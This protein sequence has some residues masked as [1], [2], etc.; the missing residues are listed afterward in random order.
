MRWG[1]EGMHGSHLMPFMCVGVAYFVIAVIVPVVL[2]RTRGEQ[3]EWT[4]S[5]LI[6]STA[7]G[8]AGALGALGIILALNFGGSAIY[9]MPLVFGG[10]PVVNT[11]VSMYMSKTY[12]EAGPLFFAGLILV[13]TGAAAVLYFNP[14]AKA[15]KSIS[16]GDFVKVLCSIALTAVCWGG[17]GPV[18]HKGQMAMRG[19]RLRPF[20]CVGLAY[21]LVAVC[22]PSLLKLIGQDHGEFTLSGASW[23]LAGGTAGA[24]GALG[25]ILA[26]TFGGKPVMVMP[27]VFG[28]AP[29][30]NTLLSIAT[31]KDLGEP[32]VFFYAGLLIVVAGAAT[33]LIFAP[34][35]HP[36]KK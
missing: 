20:M 5:G 6:W 35:P 28:I 15:A 31:A 18:L 36:V 17:Y 24:C 32:Q 1:T 22:V 9:V 25:I 27:L 29:V 2:L 16:A 12:R 23:S 19:S 7:A 26:F 34:K 30:I 10:A 14:A 11:F 4:S 33:V 8:A 3:G 21:F 13:I